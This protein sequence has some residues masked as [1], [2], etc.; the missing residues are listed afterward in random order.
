MAGVLG[1]VRREGSPAT[2]RHGGRDAG[3]AIAISALPT[4]TGT[5]RFR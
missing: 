1:P 5:I 2:L 4:K 3:Y